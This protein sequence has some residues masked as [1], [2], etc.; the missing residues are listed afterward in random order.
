MDHWLDAGRFGIAWILEICHS[1]I[2]ALGLSGMC[3]LDNEGRYY[4]LSPQAEIK[5]TT[6]STTHKSS[7]YYNANKIWEL[8]TMQSGMW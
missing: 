4:K 6:H 8:I 5:C 2:A 1:E 3:F 7:A